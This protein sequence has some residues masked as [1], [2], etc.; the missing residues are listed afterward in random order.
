MSPEV[1]GVVIGYL[2]A[3]AAPIACIG[4][5]FLIFRRVNKIYGLLQERE[6]FFFN[7]LKDDFREELKR[8]E[9]MVKK[10]KKAIDPDDLP[11]DFGKVK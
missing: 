2:F 10:R 7:D 9:R 1:W 5:L 3:L 11:P 8:N 4:L 6:F